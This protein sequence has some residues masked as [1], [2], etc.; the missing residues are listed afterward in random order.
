MSNATDHM[1][2]YNDIADDY[3]Q[4]KKHIAYRSNHAMTFH[5]IPTKCN[6]PCN[7]Q[8]PTRMVAQYGMIVGY[9]DSCMLDLVL[10]A[11]S[12]TIKSTN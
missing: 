2:A 8:P 1:S 12:V 9:C 11:G 6:G 5:K 3:S 7:D 10:M 4:P